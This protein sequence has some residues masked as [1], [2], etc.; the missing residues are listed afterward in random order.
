MVPRSATR[1]FKGDH[2]AFNSGRE[3]ICRFV[4]VIHAAVSLQKD[5]SSETN[6]YRYMGVWLHFTVFILE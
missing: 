3:H 2:S 1:H 5:G 6:E 4:N